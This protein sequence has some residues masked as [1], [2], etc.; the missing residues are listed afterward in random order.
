MNSLCYIP[1]T[2]LLCCILS[3]GQSSTR[4]S[5]EGNQDTLGR[6]EEDPYLRVEEAARLSDPDE[7]LQAKERLVNKVL[8]KQLREGANIYN[9][10]TDIPKDAFGMEELQAVTFKLSYFL[11]NN[12]YRDIEKEIFAKKIKEIFGR[13]LPAGDGEGFLY[14]N[15]FEPCNNKP[16]YHRNNGID[17]NGFFIVS[18]ENFI[19]EFYY[20]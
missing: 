18:P 1:H 4:Q 17:Y 3:C 11:W 5:A 9:D 15:L 14:V 2:L 6:I 10:V 8:E 13:T 12:D 16:F 7:Y 20:L 19:T